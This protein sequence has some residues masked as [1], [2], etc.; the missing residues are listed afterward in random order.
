MTSLAIIGGSGA[1]D[2]LKKKTFNKL[3]PC[4]KIKTPFGQSANIHTF[5]LDGISFLF[6]SRHG[7]DGY[8]TSAPFVNYRANVWALKEA[9]IERIISWSGPGI[10]NPSFDVGSYTVPHD[11]IDQTKCRA[12]TFFEH[13]G[14]G[15]IR[16]KNPFCTDLRHALLYSLESLNLNFQEHSVYVCTEGPRLETPAEIHL[17][18]SYG[19]DL[20]GMTLA[21]EAFLARELEMCYAPICYL[22]NFAEGVCDRAYLTGELFE[23]MMTKDEKHDV[24]EAVKRLPTIASLAL[25]TASDHPRECECSNAMV[26]YKK[27]GDITDDW[28]TWIDP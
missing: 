5:E 28:H 2:L 6:M 19:A 21:P 10:I 7:D 26:R 23:G 18:H 12:G 13:G 3:K 22:T 17:Y 11:I 24:D 27:R 8:K 9:G 4:R 1:Y 25:K 14:L 20:V 15:F 16:M